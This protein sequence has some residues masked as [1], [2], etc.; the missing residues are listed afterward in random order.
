[1]LENHF[2]NVFGSSSTT[3][4][5][6]GGNMTNT[7]VN[8]DPL[9][10]MYDSIGRINPR[11]G[12]TEFNMVENM[13][14][15]QMARVQGRSIDDIKND[16]IQGNY[17]APA[18]D[19]KPREYAMPS[20]ESINELARIASQGNGSSMQQNQGINQPLD[21]H[22]YGDLN[23]KSP[24]GETINLTQMIQNDP[25]LI[26]RVTELI[27]SQIGKNIHGGKTE[28]NRNRFAYT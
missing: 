8:F 4:N 14:M 13:R 2:A 15:A 12:E 25:M 21:V 3:N 23:L 27:V 17:V 1:M 7:S 10:V 24:T 16:F 6:Y 20:T 18:P 5:R 9:R 19:R 11:T 26:R 28:V 22:I